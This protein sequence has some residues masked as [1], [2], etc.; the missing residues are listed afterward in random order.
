MRFYRRTCGLLQKVGFESQPL[1]RTYRN[2]YV[3]ENMLALT[4]GPPQTAITMHVPNRQLYI[5]GSWQ[6]P[7]QG[8]TFD[9][10]SPSTGSKLGTIPAA[11]AEDVDKAITAALK[12]YKSEVWSKKSGAYRA[13]FLRAIAEQVCIEIKFTENLDKHL[14]SL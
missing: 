3:A 7:A 6:R 2:T 13:K 14:L 10:Y 8:K 4:L 12:T 1:L 5:D 9:V 11:T